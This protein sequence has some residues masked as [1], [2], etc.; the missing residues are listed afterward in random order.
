MPVKISRHGR[1]KQKTAPGIDRPLKPPLHFRKAQTIPDQRPATPRISRFQPPSFLEQVI[2]K[3]AIFGMQQGLAANG[4]NKPL[5][6]I[7]RV[8][9][10]P[11]CRKV[12]KIRL[13]VM[14]A[15]AGTVGALPVAGIGDIYFNNG[16]F[17]NLAHV[18]PPVNGYH[19]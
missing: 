5:I 12:H 2:A 6:A 4:G 19:A 8:H 7:Q 17:A 15:K 13:L 3:A 18:P 14:P 16:H 10:S 11:E 1:E 9:G